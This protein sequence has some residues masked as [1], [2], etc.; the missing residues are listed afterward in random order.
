[1]AD[2]NLP[3][4]P[5]GIPIRAARRDGFGREPPALDSEA[6]SLAGERVHQTGGVADEQ[7]PGRGDRFA[8]CIQGQGVAV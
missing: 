3:V 7:R 2:S 8:V 5:R 4:Y 6:D 1:M